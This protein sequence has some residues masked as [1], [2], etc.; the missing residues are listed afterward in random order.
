MYLLSSD[1]PGSRVLAGFGRVLCKTIVCKAIC[2]CFGQGLECG[3]CK[4][5]LGKGSLTSKCIGLLV[6]LQVLV[7]LDR[8][9][10]VS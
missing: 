8:N 5:S 6:G 1:L 9:L 4:A 10:H 7:V 2:H 3:F